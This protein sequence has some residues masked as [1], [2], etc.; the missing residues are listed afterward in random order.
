MTMA[1]E[2]KPEALTLTDEVRP[3]WIMSWQQ[4]YQTH[5][6]IPVPLFLSNYFE[7]V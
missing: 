3:F 5:P 2:N 7:T 1:Y 4:I 6:Q